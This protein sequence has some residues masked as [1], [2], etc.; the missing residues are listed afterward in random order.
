MYWHNKVI[1]RVEGERPDLQNAYANIPSKL[2][3]GAT[4]F[5]PNMDINNVVDVPAELLTDATLLVEAA[6]SGGGRTS[7]GLA[8]VIASTDGRPL[9]PFRTKHY[10]NGDHAFFVAPQLVRVVAAVSRAGW[11]IEI[12]KV[13]VSR[14][15]QSV[16]LV[17]QTLWRGHS[18]DEL[19]QLHQRFAAA[20]KA[21]MAKATHYHCRDVHYARQ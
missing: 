5:F 6:E 1:V 17:T 2:V 20:V 13:S 15:D 16:R 21:A 7:T 14:T 3:K 11:E 12:E 8:C 18:L 4:L 10:S 9:R 19:P